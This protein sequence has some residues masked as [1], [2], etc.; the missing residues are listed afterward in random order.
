MRCLKVAP[1]V[2]PWS[3]STT[4]SYG[5]RRVPPRPLDAAELLVE[6]AQRLHRVGPLEPRVVRDLVVARERRIDRGAAAHHVGEHAEHDQVADDH[7]HRRPQQRIDPA[8]VAARAH[9]AAGRPDRRRPLEQHLPPEQDQR[10]RDVEPVGEERPVARIRPLLGLHAADREDHLVGLAGEQV[11][12]A[13]AAVRRAG[14]RRSRGA[15][16]SRRSRPAPSRSSASRSPSPPTGTPG[17]PRSTRAG[18]RP[19]SRPSARTGRAPTRRGGS[20]PP[21]STAPSFGAL[22]SRIAWRSTGSARPSISRKR[23]PGTSVRVLPALA[24]RDPLDHPQRVLVVVVR[25]SHDLKHDRDG[26]HHQRRQQR[27]PERVDG[28][29]VGEHVVGEQQRERVDEQHE[30]EAEREHERQPQRRDHRREDR[31]DDRDHRGDQEAPR[32]GARGSRRGQGRPR[33]TARPPRRSRRRAAARAAAAA[34][35]GSHA[36]GVP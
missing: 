8:A 6:L 23:I 14:R 29:E 4:I 11:A 34:S 17:C 31:V 2:C 22:P 10:P 20:R 35:T 3:E 32:R 16:R 36:T 9:V 7:A 19:G 1:C 27:V 24:A 13:R 25:A 12:A 28:D 26:G 15:A 33:R 30:Q 18:C 5:P 21:R